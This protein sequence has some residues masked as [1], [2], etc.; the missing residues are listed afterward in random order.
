MCHSGTDLTRTG[1]VLLFDVA[2]AFPPGR[3]GVRLLVELTGIEGNSR[4]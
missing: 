3:A 2:G 4:L 1:Y